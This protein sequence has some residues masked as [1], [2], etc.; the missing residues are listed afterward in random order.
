MQYAQELL[1]P[2][3]GSDLSAGV[4]V[5]AELDQNP[6]HAPEQLEVLCVEQAEQD[7]HALT[8]LQLLPHLPHRTQQPQQL[9]T[10]PETRPQVFTYN[11]LILIRHIM[12]SLHKTHSNLNIREYTC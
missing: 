4:G 10:H 7:G 12:T 8:G 3:P 1:H 9:R 5:L 11:P 2:A 6:D